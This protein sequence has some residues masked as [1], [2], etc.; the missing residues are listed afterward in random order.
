MPRDDVQVGAASWE[1]EGEGEGGS[2]LMDVAPPGILCD[3]SMHG[4]VCDLN[5]I[6]R[7]TCQLL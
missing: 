1:G 3:E 7:H 4:I 5:A 2:A 6:S